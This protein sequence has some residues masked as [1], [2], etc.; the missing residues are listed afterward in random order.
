MK[1]LMRWYYKNEKLISQLLK[2]FRLLIEIL[3][4]IARL[5]KP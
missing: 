4:A 1:K 5:T 3:H 2:H